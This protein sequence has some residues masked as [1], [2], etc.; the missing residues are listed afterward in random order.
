MP[1]PEKV[2]ESSSWA[3]EGRSSESNVRHC[4]TFLM[5]ACKQ[6]ACVMKKEGNLARRE[7]YMVVIKIANK[8]FTPRN[9]S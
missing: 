9:C 7:L 5:G 8:S 6:E 3:A 2:S 1:M 4:L